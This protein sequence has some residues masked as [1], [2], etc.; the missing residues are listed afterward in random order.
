MRMGKLAPA[1]NKCQLTH[2][3]T[4]SG[5]K[6]VTSMTRAKCTVCHVINISGHQAHYGNALGPPIYS[7][8]TYA[9]G[10]RARDST[11]DEDQRVN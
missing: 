6:P 1:T 10:S 2:V 7:R 8:I 4:S 9:E 3:K 5:R 11:D